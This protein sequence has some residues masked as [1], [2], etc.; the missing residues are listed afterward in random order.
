MLLSGVHNVWIIVASFTTPFLFLLLYLAWRDS[1]ENQVF[2]RSVKSIAAGFGLI[3]A[4]L[5]AFNFDQVVRS[6]IVSDRNRDIL[7]LF[8]DAKFSIEERM[9]VVCRL[10]LEH[11]CSDLIAINDQIAFAALLDMLES[12]KR[13]TALEETQRGPELT[14]IIGR[15][16]RHIEQMNSRND[17]F[18]YETS[19]EQYRK[20]LAGYLVH[21]ADTLG[22]DCEPRRSCVSGAAGISPEKIGSTSFAMMATSNYAGFFAL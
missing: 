1:P 17:A 7:F 20:N 11:Q 8:L 14:Y 3:G 16:N 18:F 21:D 22:N 9:A 6:T 12:G 5:V 4:I 2:W 15:V 19:P 13:L 10:G